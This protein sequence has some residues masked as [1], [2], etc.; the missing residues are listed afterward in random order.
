MEQDTEERIVEIPADLL[1]ALDSH[2]AARDYF[3]GLSYSHKKEY[4]EY[5]TEA[6]KLETRVGRVRKTLELLLAQAK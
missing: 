3:D 1:T 2:P 4:V 5:I 6:K